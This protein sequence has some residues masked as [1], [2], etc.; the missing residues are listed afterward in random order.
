MSV[1]SQ[2]FKPLPSATAGIGEKLYDVVLDKRKSQALSNARQPDG[3]VDYQAAAA[4]ISKFD[5]DYAMSMQKMMREDNVWQAVPSR[6]VMVHR[7]TG[8]I[9]PLETGAS[10]LMTPEQ[11]ERKTILQELKLPQNESTYKNLR[12]RA[13]EI[14]LPEAQYMPER[15]NKEAIEQILYSRLPMKD[16]Y[17]AMQGGQRADATQYRADIQKQKLEQQERKL[18]RL[19]SYRNRSLDLRNKQLEFRKNKPLRKQEIEQKEQFE[20]LPWQLKPFYL[21]DEK[22]QPLTELTREDNKNAREAIKVYKRIKNGINKIEKI[23]SSEKAFRKNQLSPSKRAELSSLIR[24]L[25]L[26]EKE[27]QNLGVLNGPDLSLMEEIIKNPN[28]AILYDRWRASFDSFKNKVDDDFIGDMST[29]GIDVPG[30]DVIMIKRPSKSKA[31]Y[32]PKVG[33]VNTPQRQEPVETNFD[34]AEYET[35][36]S[37]D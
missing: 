17:K 25:Q 3:T 11:E 8:E 4:E 15:Y 29:M 36:F 14:G 31:N 33:D 32:V 10:K 27:R 2:I 12:K 34:D 7:G 28:E 18:T 1:W 6:G 20:N 16:Y 19:E 9:K 23:T 22:G 5:P 30:V 26:T 35:Y 37:L 24:G 13:I 21:T